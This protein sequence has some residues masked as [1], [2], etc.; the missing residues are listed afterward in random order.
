MQDSFITS[1]LSKNEEV[2]ALFHLHSIAWIGIIAPLVLAV[3][4]GI[5]C[6]AASSIQGAGGLW[7]FP[8]FMVVMALC[9]YL[10]MISTE[11]GV[12]NKRVV[13]KTGFIFRKNIDIRLNKIESVVLDQGIF[14][15][16]FGFGSIVFNGTGS[17]KSVFLNIDNPLQAKNVINQ[18][19]E[20]M[21]NEKAAQKTTE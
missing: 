12:T 10:G 5:G 20:D 4:A 3:I 16:I 6:I 2:K 21:E 15:R 19:L 8:L 13:G 1:T 17:G 7:I 14:G 11:Y 18:I 9:A